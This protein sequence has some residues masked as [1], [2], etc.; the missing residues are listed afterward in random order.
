MP[1]KSVAVTH[2]P[3][4]EVMACSID[5]ER[6][7]WKYSVSPWRSWIVGM[8]TGPPSRTKPTWQKRASSK[9]AWIVASS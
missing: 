5:A 1:S 6:E 4:G 3:A 8:T 2:A 9:I 7:P